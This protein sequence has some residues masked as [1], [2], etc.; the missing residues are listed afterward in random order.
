MLSARAWR[1]REQHPMLLKVIRYWDGKVA[2]QSGIKYL[3]GVI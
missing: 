3:T 2:D 1:L